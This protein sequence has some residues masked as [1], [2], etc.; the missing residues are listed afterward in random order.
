MQLIPKAF[1]GFVLLEICL[2]SKDTSRNRTHYLPITYQA[3][4]PIE[5]PVATDIKML[6][7]GLVLLEIGVESKDMSGN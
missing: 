6:F 1:A 7:G 4:L 3:S 5:P 2:E